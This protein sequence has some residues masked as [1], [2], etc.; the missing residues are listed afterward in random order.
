MCPRLLAWE[1]L[2]LLADMTSH[3]V[4]SPW[5]MRFSIWNTISRSGTGKCQLSA[6]G[7]WPLMSCVAFWVAALAV[8][9]IISLDL[10]SNLKRQRCRP[11]LSRYSMKLVEGNWVIWAHKGWREQAW[12]PSIRLSSANTC[13]L[14]SIPAAGGGW[15]TNGLM[16]DYG[17]TLLLWKENPAWRQCV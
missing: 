7:W 1:S 13:P 3:R 16:R 12:D 17:G 9:Y 11:A 4:T 2:T 8:V 14:C 15:E 5:W 6:R 10:C